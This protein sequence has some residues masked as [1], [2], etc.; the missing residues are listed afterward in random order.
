MTDYN[1]CA[2]YTAGAATSRS[3]RP[4][5]SRHC[6]DSRIRGAERRS[7]VGFLDASCIDDV[8]I[9]DLFAVKSFLTSSASAVF[10][11]ASWKTY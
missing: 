9:E 4:R 11:R 1:D 10:T 3:L 7:L 6:C 5:G 8:W 2:Y